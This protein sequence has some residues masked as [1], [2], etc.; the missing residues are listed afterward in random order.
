MS[1]FLDPSEEIR[2]HGSKLPHWQ[3]D[4]VMQ[5]VT[6]RLGD[7][8]PQ[9]KLR[10]WSENRRIFLEQNPKPWTEETEFEFRRRFTQRIEE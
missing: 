1:D 3:Q 7:S 10:E 9:S 6:F 2:K 5:F 4:G 8:L